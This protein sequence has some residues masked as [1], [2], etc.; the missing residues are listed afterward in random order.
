M[1]VLI[2]HMWIYEVNIVTYFYHSLIHSTNTYQALIV[3][4][5]YLLIDAESWE[6][7]V[8][9]AVTIP[10]LVLHYNDHFLIYVVQKYC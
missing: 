8:S 5:T 4:Q 10:V 1:C 7:T 6:I 3:C 2:R 9:N